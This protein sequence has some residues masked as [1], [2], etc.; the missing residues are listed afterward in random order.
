MKEK[1]MEI[2]KI[3]SNEQTEMR[4]LTN[5]LKGHWGLHL[6]PILCKLRQLSF[7]LLIFIYLYIY[8]YIYH[9]LLF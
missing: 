8:I 6:E 4:V 3:S 1:N 5:V 9:Y 7:V 2:V